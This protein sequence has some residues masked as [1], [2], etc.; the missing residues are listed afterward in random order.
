MCRP[1]IGTFK[2]HLIQESPLQL[3]ASQPPFLKEASFAL[4]QP[5]TGRAQICEASDSILP[6]VF[7]DWRRWT[8]S[9]GSRNHSPQME[10]QLSGV[11]MTPSRSVAIQP[12]R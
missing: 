11:H 4:D 1:Q 8:L 3:R 5:P 10:H 2:I 9:V 7:H 6:N 12:P